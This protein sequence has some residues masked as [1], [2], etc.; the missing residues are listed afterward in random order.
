MEFGN[1]HFLTYVNIKPMIY[2][3]DKYEFI[4]WLIDCIFFF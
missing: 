2:L 4:Y 3:L 1:S